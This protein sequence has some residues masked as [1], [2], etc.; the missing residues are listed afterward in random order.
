MAGGNYLENELGLGWFGG[1]VG[2]GL[3]GLVGTVT[4]GVGGLIGGFGGSSRGYYSESHTAVGGAVAG[5]RL[6]GDDNLMAMASS[7]GASQAGVALLRSVAENMENESRDAIANDPNRAI[8][9]R[10]AGSHSLLAK[11]QPGHDDSSQDILRTRKFE[12]ARALSIASDRMVIGQMRAALTNPD[13]ASAMAQLEAIDQTID[14]L[15]ASPTPGHPLFGI[16]EEHRQAIEEAL[17]A[18]YRT[19]TP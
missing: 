7:L 16:I 5:A 10:A 12:L 2:A 15:I 3:G 11:D 14:T 13:S 17:T 1:A 9:G 18:H 8:V 6:F 4:G 19:A